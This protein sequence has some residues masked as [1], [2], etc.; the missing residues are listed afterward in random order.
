MGETGNPSSASRMA[1]RQRLRQRDGA[2]LLEQ[3]GPSA[4]A[5]GTVIGLGA[6]AGHRLLSPRRGARRESCR[7]PT[8]PLALSADQPLSLADQISA[9]MS[10]PI[11]VMCG[12]TRLSTAA[13]VTAASMALPPP[14]EHGQ[15]RGR[16]ERLAG[17]DHAV[18]GVDRRATRRCARRRGLGC[19]RRDQEN[20][21]GNCESGSDWVELRG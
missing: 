11:P 13:A 2:V 16:S 14:L 21:R 19:Q 3:L 4:S 6:I 5:P 17:G 12:S 9:N 10:P 7:A 18:R 1:G 15:T 8:R 20:R